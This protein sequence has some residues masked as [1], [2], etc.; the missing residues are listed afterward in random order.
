MKVVKYQ[1]VS[2]QNQEVENQTNSI[3]KQIELLGWT[4]VGEYKEVM[5][6]TKSKDTRPQLR[7]LLADARK[8]KFDR[9]IVFALDRLG[10]SVVDVINTIHELEEVGV[11]IFVV[12]NSIDTSTSQGKMFSYFINIFSEMERDMIIS[13]QKQSIERIREKGGKWGNGNLISQEKRDKIVLLK[14]EGLSYRN[15][16]KELDISL[17]SVQHT[18]KTHSITSHAIDL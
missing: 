2:T 8:R 16:C 1:R 17:G 14:T 6:G 5:S 9:V 7:Q 3:D 12:K 15:I 4:C 11:N 13:R 10:R 18:L